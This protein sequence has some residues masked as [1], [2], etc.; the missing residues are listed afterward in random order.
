MPRAA[1]FWG[2]VL[3]LGSV[4]LVQAQSTSTQQNPV[5]TFA[6]PGSYPVT[7]K[8]CNWW[9]CTTIVKTVTVLDPKPAIL[10]AVVGAS[11][12]EAGQLV[13]LSGSGKGM[14]PLAYTWRLF[15]GVTLVRE[16]PGALGWLDTKGLAPGIY[17]L[18]LRI[19]NAAGAA[20]SL[21]G[22][23]AIVPAASGDF[24]VVTPCRLLDTRSGAPLQ[25]GVTRLVT[26]AGACGV[27]AGARALAANITIVSATGQGSL[28]AFPGNYPA[29]GTLTVSFPPG[30]ALTNNG[31]LPL[32]TDGMARLA[33]LATIPGNGT[34][35]VAV[36]VF[37]YFLP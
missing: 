28:V 12:A 37:G 24:Y 3:L 9:K 25:S 34:V 21:P 33:M 1:A 20:E 2:G 31:I 17:T 36:D 5:H 7:L 18:L 19:T 27:P 26:A 29:P 30:Q 11:T 8:V 22:A 4:A 10:S 14:P 23:L 16:V 35:H 32:S 13:P 6:V 15:K